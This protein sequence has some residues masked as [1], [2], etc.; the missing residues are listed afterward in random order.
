MIWFLKLLN[1]FNKQNKTS[2]LCKLCQLDKKSKNGRKYKSRQY[3]I[4]KEKMTVLQKK[5][6]I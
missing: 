3:K 1:T 5:L 2:G 6:K 4:S